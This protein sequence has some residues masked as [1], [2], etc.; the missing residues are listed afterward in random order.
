MTLS[1]MTLCK[2]QLP[3]HRDGTLTTDAE[4]SLLSKLSPVWLPDQ[5]KLHGQ[6]HNAGSTAQ[7]LNT[8]H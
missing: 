3:Q 5:T 6:V 1:C 8:H 7:G 4:Q 2:M